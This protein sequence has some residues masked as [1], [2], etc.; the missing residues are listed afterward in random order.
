MVREHTDLP[1]D[2]VLSPEEVAKNEP[3]LIKLA[4]A[5]PLRIRLKGVKPEERPADLAPEQAVLA[6]PDAVLRGLSAEY[7]ATLPA[8]V[9]A[10]VR[11]RLA[12]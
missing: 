8:D 6:L 10:T 12:R 4:N 1:E 2:A 7:L 9:Q 3:M 5:I 11:A